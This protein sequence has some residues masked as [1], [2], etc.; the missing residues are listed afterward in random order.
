MSDVCK[1]CTNAGLMDRLPDGRADRTEFDTVIVQ[2]DVGQT[3][4]LTAYRRARSA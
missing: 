2:P 1:H 4:R 3:A